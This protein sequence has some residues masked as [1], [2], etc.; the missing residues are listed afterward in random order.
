MYALIAYVKSHV[1]I[2][3]RERP[4]FVVTVEFK[5]KPDAVAAFKPLME[6]NTRVSLDTEEGCLQF[7]VCYDAGRPAEMFQYE[8]QRPSR[9]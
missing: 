9:L 2:G 6:A 1:E 7:D 5:I 3:N 8:I 4:M